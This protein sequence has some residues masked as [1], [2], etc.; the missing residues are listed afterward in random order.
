MS[1]KTLHLLIVDDEESIR[2]LL[3]DNLIRKYH[4]EVDTA[5]DS[6]AALELI[7]HFCGRYDVALIDQV[8]EGSISGL[9]LL[10]QIK[11]TYPE[12]QVIV[13]TGWGMKQEE[14]IKILNLGAYRYIAKP[15]NLDELALTIRFAAEQR[16]IRREHVYL[17][18]LGQVSKE[19][20]RT[21]DLEKQ[22]AL[23]WRYVKDQLSTPTFF[24]AIYDCETDTLGFHQS[25]DEGEPDPLIDRYL[26][27]NPS[28]WGV[29][30]H[31]VKLKQEIAWLSHDESEKKWQEL[32]IKPHVSGK[33]PS[34]AGICLPLQVGEK[35]IG[36][37]SVQSYQPQ[38]FDDAFLNA[39]RT[40]GGQL[41]PAI[42]NSKLISDLEKTKSHLIGL[43]EG[44][45]D[46]AV[47]IDVN[48]H[49]TVFNK[50]AEE[51]FGYTTEEMVGHTVAVL[52]SDINQARV[53]WNLIEQHKKIIGH[54]VILKHKNGMEIPVLLSAVSVRNQEGRIIGQAGFL[55][56]MRRMHLL[57]ERLRSLIRAGQAISSLRD[58]D[59]ILQ[60]IIESAVAAFPTTEKGS[61][62]LFDEKTRRL[63]I[64]AYVGYPPRVADAATLMIGEGFAGWVY[65]HG[66]PIVSGNTQE[67][68]RFKAFE[69]ETIEM[70]V[71]KSIVCTPLIVKG[72]VI[73]TLSLD[74]LTR[75]DAFNPDDVELLS[76]FASQ[77]ANAIENSRL[78]METH[79]REQ[80]LAA[81]DE[82]SRHIRA[83]REPQKLLHEIVRL[84]VELSGCT[85]G[86]LLINYQQISELVL[87][88]TYGLSN[89][90]V[91]TRLSYDGPIG[92]VA[93]SGDFQV[94]PGFSCRADQEQIFRGLDLQTIVALPLRHVGGVDAVLFVADVT[95][96]RFFDKNDQEILE[97]Y[98]VQASIALHTSQLL[99]KEQRPL[100]QLA[101]LHRISDYIQK[102]RDLDKILHVV[103]TGVTAGYGL[104]FN[105]AALLLLNEASTVLDGR[106]GIGFLLEADAQVDWQIHHQRGLEDF[107]KYLEVS[108]KGTLPET[109]VNQN[110]RLV[111][112][113]VNKKRPNLFSRVVFDKGWKL[114]AEDE[115]K[116]IPDEFIK[117]FE[118]ACPLI[119]V[120]LIAREMV[121]GLLVADNKFTRLPVTQEDINS[122]VTFTN[123]AAI[124][125]NN[126]QLFHD[127]EMAREIIRSSFEASAALAASQNPEKVLEAIVEQA[128]VVSGALWVSIMLIDEIGQVRDLVTTRKDKSAPLHSLIR[129]NGLTMD[130]M[131]SGKPVVIQN[132][133][134]QLDQINRRMLEMGVKAAMCMPL[135]LRKKQ[136]GVMWVQYDEPRLFHEYEIEA[137]QLYVNQAVTAY[138]NTRRFRE[139]EYLHNAAQAVAAPLMSRDVLKQIVKSACEVLQADSS[140]LWS[141]DDTHNRFVPEELVA[142]RIPLTKLDRVRK[143]E[144]RKGGTADT[145]MEKGWVGVSNIADAEYDFTGSSTIA[146]LNNVGAKSF[147]GIALKVGDERLGVLFVNYNHLRVFTHRDK[148]ILETLAS[149]AAIALKKARLLDELGVALKQVTRARNA[150]QIVA[151]VT[152]LEVL[153]GTLDS[154]VHGTKN[155]LGCDVVTLYTYDEEKSEFAFPP[156]AIG[157]N[158][159]KMI[160]DDG[161][162][163]RD[164]VPYKIISLNQPY[165]SSHDESDPIMG[166]P[167]SVREGTKSSVAV[168]LIAGGRKVG[169]LFANFRNR[170]IFSDEDLINIKLFAQQA[171]VAI[172]NARLYNAAKQRADNLN[173]ILNISQTT[174]S[175]L[176]LRQ[177][178]SATCQAAVDLLRVDHSGLVLFDQDLEKGRVCAEYPEIGANGVVF[179]LK[180][181]PAE[182]KL[183]ATKEPLMI[184]DVAS[185]TGFDPVRDV[186]AAMGPC[187]MLIVP[188]LSQSRMLGSFGLDMMKHHRVFTKEEIETCK[189]FAAQVAV[190]IENARLYEIAKRQ[191][192]EAEALRKVSQVLSTTLDPD[193][194]FKL[195]F[196]EL[197]KVVPYDSASLQVLTD[198]HLKIISMSG[199]QEA[200]QSVAQVW[201]LDDKIPN[202]AVI[203]TRQPLIV[204]F[205]QEKYEIFKDPRHIRIECWLGV[206]LLV[207]DRVIG[208]LTLDKYEPDFYTEDHARLAMAF[209]TQA[210]ITLENANLYEQEQ[211]V[212]NISREATKSLE[213]DTFL[214]SLFSTLKQVFENRHIPVHLSLATYNKEIRSL[215]S[216]YTNFYPDK[217]RPDVIPLNTR[218]IMPWVAKSWMAKK[219]GLYYASNVEQDPHYLCLLP[220]TRSEIAVPISFR[221]ELL[222][223]LDVESP[224][225]NAF[226]RW[227]KQ[228]L[229]T[230]ADQL[231]ATIQNVRQFD[232]LRHTYEQLRQTKGLVSARTTLAWMGLATNQWRHIIEGHAINIRN[233]VT[234]LRRDIAKIGGNQK[235]LPNI[236]E[237]LMRIENL[238]S[239]IEEKP[240]TPPL[241]SEE[242]LRRIAVSP[243]VQE[244]LQ[245]LWQNEPYK[246]I[247]L[248]TKVQVKDSI[249]VRISPEWLRRA[250]DILIDNAVDELQNV[251]HSNRAISVIT[252]LGNDGVEIVVSDTGKGIPKDVL[253]Q[254]FVK[255]VERQAKTKGLGM[256][257]LIAQAIAETYGGK[258]YCENT[259]R[260][261]TVMII[262]LPVRFQ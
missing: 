262:W 204:N 16:Q 84:A 20:T 261:G 186:L 13:F 159:E 1:E 242:G 110:I 34:E 126:F 86:G 173:A 72:K 150:A 210:A 183:I 37:L 77:A 90:L 133:N 197:Q 10:E 231:A 252:R 247:H 218:G 105:R 82:A 185:E 95:G 38:A 40:L 232:E 223:V 154:I 6:K 51:M 55:R 144:P 43:V 172:E 15:F 143:Q 156:A 229:Q 113:P 194:V 98:A 89:D 138:E 137:M 243:L 41:A 47:F 196:R 45:I 187:S 163:A 171:A 61:I 29:A 181:V 39:V 177:I 62:H 206:P 36:V 66:I 127:A 257:L 30:G 147:E 170:H 160:L 31:V 49:V 42:E 191:R 17:S 216:H 35:I 221:G 92:Q 155:S 227:D 108:E 246:A 213:L 71:P 212:A 136:F 88:T 157:I 116:D 250:L 111:H 131:R 83:E 129:E 178:L 119:V 79:S 146:L 22:L 50:R 145:V 123:T 209:A 64:K 87:K 67:D 14:G 18:A 112:V 118:P 192:S 201:T 8:L 100:S 81:L 122:L 176:D 141:Y 28:Q 94:I 164:S 128:Q 207:G 130:V 3:A 158:D 107:G 97:R 73:G 76:S 219:G 233:I 63:Y 121:I 99:D 182:E 161:F 169:V 106:M 251:S 249:T 214:N 25:Y 260:S 234:L 26:G 80:L 184:P 48:R 24:V 140:A 239:K 180:G 114:I 7:D 256:G 253:K 4:Y 59:Q 202:S 32:G 58:T 103:L 208:M 132:V 254:I 215:V 189:V 230:L 117:A 75:F 238:A 68:A 9:E 224:I 237:N 120:P 195:I 162:V 21:A 101:I 115:L 151:E 124:A 65:E 70:L 244:R 190:A 54:E 203:S 52:Y 199:S 211:I 91:G 198:R 193:Q 236:E 27:D 69:F 102:A 149:H 46:A 33:G 168:P 175:S 93:R 78:Y 2:K 152:A 85:V 174:I 235:L 44:S 74:N 222:A 255:R 188:I 226:T 166:S 139:L 57:E 142:Y 56:D 245:Q 248:D 11:S 23:V 228:L 53:I 217:V 179:P 153:H 200:L 240:I 134:E 19:L 96:K 259:G 5:A 205:P 167:F 125:I 135:S 60:L 241:S 12:I 258:I 225:G 148:R 109:P 104:G 165:V 220:S